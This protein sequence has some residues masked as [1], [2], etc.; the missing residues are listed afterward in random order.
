M[1]KSIKS[2][3]FGSTSFDIIFKPTAFPV[4]SSWMRDAGC[5]SVYI[6]TLIHA[7]ELHEKSSTPGEACTSGKAIKSGFDKS[8]P[9]TKS[10]G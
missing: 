10:I 5:K 6:F 2:Q 9:N 8:S 1:F 3:L 4:C 7:C